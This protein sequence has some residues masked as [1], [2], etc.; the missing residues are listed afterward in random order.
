M[1][2]SVGRKNRS[3]I[4][5][6]IDTTG[7]HELQVAYFDNIGPA[8][9]NMNWEYLGGKDD[10]VGAWKGEYFNNRDLAGAPLMTRQDSGI[11]FDWNSGSPDSRIP[12]DNFSARWTRSMY[13]EGGH[14][15]FRVQHDDGMRVYIDDKIIYDSWFDQEVNY[16]VGVVPI[17]QGF[18]PIKVEFYDHVGNA[19]VRFT[20][21]EDPTDYDDVA[22][23]PNEPGTIVDNASQ[24]FRWAGPERNTERGGF[25]DNFFWVPNKTQAMVNYGQW[26]PQLPGAGNYEVMAYI[27][28][29][30]ATTKNATYRIQHF[31]RVAERSLD[32]SRYQSEWASL[33]MYYF[34]GQGNEFVVLQDNTGEAQGST[35][36]AFDAL[37]FVKR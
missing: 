30:R 26:V 1:P 4:R 21:D 22:V 18:R 7:D 13:L 5:I 28:S 35:Q 6:Y 27:P 12:R 16:E 20:I 33:G 3:Q 9:I 25:G 23:D 34:D 15:T 2:V 37:K 31:G 19:V 11:N 14:Y 24:G 32:Q 36:L 10:I 8:S 29:N 17:K